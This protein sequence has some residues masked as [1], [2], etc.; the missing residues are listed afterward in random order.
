VERTLERVDH[1]V[2]DWKGIKGEDK[3]CIVRLLD[4]IGLPFDKA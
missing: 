1:A 3:P 4:E 2:L